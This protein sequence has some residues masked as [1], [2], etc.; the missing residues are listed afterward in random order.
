MPKVLVTGGAGFIGS[1][2]CLVLLEAGF[3]VVALDNFSNSS[4]EPLVRVQRLTKKSLDVIEGDVRNEHVLKQIFSEHNFDSVYHFAGLKS[5]SESGSKPLEYYST[6]IEGTVRICDAMF[7]ASVFKLVFSS[8]CTVYGDPERVPIR[9][10][11]K[12][13]PPTNPYGRSKFMAEQV[14]ADL[15]AANPKWKVACLRYFNPIGAHQSG[16]IGEDPSGTP[17]NLLPFITQ[18]AVGRLD[19]LR[20]FGNDYDTPDGTGV[21][22]YIHVMDLARGH[23][24]AHGALETRSGLNIWNLGTGL[25]YSVHQVKETF[26]SVSGNKVP[27]SIESRRAGDVGMIFADPSKAHADL[28]WRASHDLKTMISDAWRWQ[29]M[30]PAGYRPA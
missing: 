1:H 22:D 13:N 27:F 30:N 16:S 20:I 12:V 28:N 19:R 8:S 25:G 23:L 15:V 9:E 24:A 3:Q 29:S 14:L 2:T 11:D 17:C 7:K 26:E 4:V 18:V 5:V 6:N 10:D 21:R